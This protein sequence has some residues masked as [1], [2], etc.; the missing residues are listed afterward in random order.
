MKRS[1]L[2]IAVLLLV[3]GCGPRTPKQ[4]LPLLEKATFENA[5]GDKPVLLYTISNKSGATLQMTNYGAR[6][7]SLWVPD[8][9]GIMRD[10]L[11]GYETAEATMRDGS[12]SGAVVGR[13]G[14]RIAAGRFTLDGKEYE[15]ATNSGGNHLHGG[16]VGWAARVWDA[17]QITDPAGNPAVKMTLVSPDG[18]E[19][20]PGTLTI[21]VTYSLTADNRVVLEYHATTTAPTVLNPTNHAYFNLHGTAG[22]LVLSHVM[23]INA[24]AF[25]PVARGNIPTGEI[26][27][28]EGTALDFRTPIAVGRG[29]ASEF[30]D[31]DASRGYDNN[32]VLNK[33]S[34]GE[35][36]LAA[37][38][39]EPSTGIVMTV[40][41]SEPGIQVYTCNS[42]S[43]TDIGKYGEARS[44][45]SSIALETQHYPDSPNH[46]NF[47]ST[48]L[49]PGETFT[50]R[51]I[52]A[53][54]TR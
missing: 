32:W 53:F 22:Q 25:T 40:F 18:E 38:V 27:P 42:A 37:E 31:P 41:T 33:T 43:P 39:Y 51:T 14:N 5:A 19:N 44:R 46:G 20:Y 47:P 34:T 52:Y 21:S 26:R 12:S 10:V 7:L 29:M 11:W 54:S 4:V 49:R 36:S 48:V 3:A 2:T 9:D 6:L 1:L 8:R 30:K 35:V 13:Y 16:N 50:S 23:T 28:V 45:H 15:L 24:D 17:E